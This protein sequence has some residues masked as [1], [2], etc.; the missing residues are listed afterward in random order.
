MALPLR[1]VSPDLKVPELLKA[2]TDCLRV[3]PKV[4]RS[5]E[6]NG[7]Q[8]IK[9]KTFLNKTCETKLNLSFIP[10]LPQ[11]SHQLR[12]RVQDDA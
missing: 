11:L 5:H 3:V 7:T 10:Q 4:L 8:A 6:M 1:L 12:H 9:P 2:P